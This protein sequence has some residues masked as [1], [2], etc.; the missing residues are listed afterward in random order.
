[1]LAPSG[2]SVAQNEQLPALQI[3]DEP[4]D[5]DREDG[6]MV[7][8]EQNDGGPDRDGNNKTREIFHGGATYT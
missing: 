6:G 7:A 4:R 1:L 2:R 3:V 8:G 5:D